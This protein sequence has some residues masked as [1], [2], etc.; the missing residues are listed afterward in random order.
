MRRIPEQLGSLTL[1]RQIGLGRHC[2]VW[3]AL[4]RSSG[5]RVAV[6][7]LVPEMA[8]DAGQRRRGGGSRELLLGEEALPAAA[9]RA[10]A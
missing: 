2:Q 6:K 4:D 8:G 3:D 9:G 5:Q 1:G 7:V 10:F